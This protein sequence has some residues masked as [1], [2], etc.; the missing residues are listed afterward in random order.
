MGKI[1]TEQYCVNL[2]GTSATY[3]A[4]KCVTKQRVYELGCYLD[5]P[6]NISDNQLVEESNIVAPEITYM[7]VGTNSFS[8][9]DKGTFEGPCS[10]TFIL[11]ESN[12]KYLKCTFDGMQFDNR[13]EFSPGERFK[14]VAEPANQTAF[15]VIG[16]TVTYEREADQVSSFC[17][18]NDLSLNIGGYTYR[19]HDSSE[20]YYELNSKSID[21]VAD[22]LIGD[23][24]QISGS[25]MFG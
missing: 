23:T 7:T 8:F 25:I 12:T 20:I 18:T 5:I 24:L 16:F 19:I 11:Y 2:S 9:V 14:F 17:T 21:G 22:F 10:I 6:E 4:N 15:S 1:V 3:I 13:V